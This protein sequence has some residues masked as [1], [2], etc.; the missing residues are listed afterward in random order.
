MPYI[1]NLNKTKDKEC[2]CDSWITHWEKHRGMAAEKCSI[3]NCKETNLVGA[4]I[5]KV[6]DDG[7]HY[8]LPLCRGHNNSNK[9]MYITIFTYYLSMVSANVQQT[10]G[11]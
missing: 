8:I 10:C 9:E 11:K 3:Y 5:K 2:E 4:H 7:K 6:K 1:K